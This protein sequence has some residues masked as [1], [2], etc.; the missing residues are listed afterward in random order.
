MPIGLSGRDILGCA[1]TGSGKTASFSIPMIQHAL[2]QEALRR[3][4]GP[5]G[6]VLAP[7]R[8]LAQQIEKE[9]RSL[10]TLLGGR[11]RTAIVVGGNQMSDQRIDLRNGVE[12]VVAT[13]GRL[14]DHLQQGN[15][16]LARVSF[17]V[18]DEADRMLDM[19]FEP[20]I[21]E[22]LGQLPAKHQTLLFSATMPE[23]VSE[24]R[25]DLT[26]AGRMARESE[27]GPPTT[28]RSRCSPT[29]IS[30]TPSGS[31]SARSAPRP[32]T[33]PSLWRRSRR[34]ARWTRC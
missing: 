19:G 5:L 26:G 11:L 14:V 20:Q 4:D 3:G 28:C 16:N 30:R 12:V 33:W 31:R 23:E 24:G 18:L 6:L 13:P 1:E 8:E 21:R 17:V 25:R 32:P 15:T 10:S 2:N 7:T 9:V 22:I 34:L 27:S 29:G